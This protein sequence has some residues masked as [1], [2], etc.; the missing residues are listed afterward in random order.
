LQLK[1]HTQ[2]SADDY[3]PRDHSLDRRLRGSLH[4]AGFDVVD[5]MMGKR[6][7]FER[8]P[9]DFYPTPYEAVVPLLPFVCEDTVWVDPCAGDGAL[10]KHFQ[11]HDIDIAG[12]DTHPMGPGIIELDAF[13]QSTEKWYDENWFGIDECVAGFITNPP[14]DWKILNPLITHLSDMAPTWLLLPADMM[15]N[16]RMAKHLDR[17]D[18]IVSVGR[19][20]WFG[21]QSGMENSAW[22]LFDTNFTDDTLFFA[23]AT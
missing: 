20:K 2:F 14:Y 8:K 10:I 19:V 5:E 17:C 13:N 22:Y 16:R 15:H 12:S 3:C 21:N 11:N 4:R 1:T 6:S 7:E 23:R 18:M 9:R